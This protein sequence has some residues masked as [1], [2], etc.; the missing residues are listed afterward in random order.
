[1]SLF[2]LYSSRLNDV[3]C[4]C[5]RLTPGGLAAATSALLDR[6]SDLI[7][8]HRS[9]FLFNSGSSTRY[10]TDL[11]P[12]FSSN[13]YY[14]LLLLLSGGGLCSVD[15]PRTWSTTHGVVGLLLFSRILQLRRRRSRKQTLFE[16]FQEVT[17]AA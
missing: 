5:R 3:T 16:L 10:F 1:M 17:I 11:L 6:K 9:I 12:L 8:H 13:L 7:N 2:V 14:L 15:E 4:S